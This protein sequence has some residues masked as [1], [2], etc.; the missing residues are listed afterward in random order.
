[1]PPRKKE[2]VDHFHNFAE[3]FK[4]NHILE[5]DIV[6]REDQIVDVMTF[7]DSPDLLNLP[8]NNF[9]LWLGQRVV[10]KTF[11]MG[12]RGNENVELTDEEWGW[13]YDRQLY[14]VIDKIKRKTDGIGPGQK[15]NFNFSE[16]H[17]VLGR[18]SSKT[19]MASV[20]V[21][22]EAYKLI[23]LGDPYQYYGL[24]YDD[25]I[26][27]L[28]AANSAKQSGRLFTQ[29][30]NRIRNSPFF[31]GR[32][33]GSASTTEIRLFTDVDL[34]K[35]EE[36]GANIAV[37][38]SIVLICGHS[39]PDTLR[40]FAAI[41]ILFDELAF[42]DEGTV[43]SGTEFYG[44]LTPSIAQFS[45]FG[46]GILVE[47]STPGPMSGIFYTIFQQANSED[48]KF[49]SI[50]SFRLSTWDFNP[51][52]PFGCE[53]LVKE[54]AKNPE[55]FSVEFGV[56]WQTKG[57]V[58]TYFP[59]DLV[60][61]SFKPFVHKHE[62]RD[63]RYEYFMHLDP[64]SK[65]DNY[66]ALV[67]LKQRYV[68]SR[69]EKRFRVVLAYHRVWKPSAGKALNLLDIDDEILLISQR[70]RPSIIT[71]DQW[72]SVHSINYLQKKG[73]RARQLPFGRT[74]KTTY[75]QNLLDLMDRDELHLYY[76]ELLMAEMLNL[77]Y[78]TTERGISIG[79]D[80]KSDV[81]TDDIIDCLAGA[82]WMAVGR[83]MRS[84]LPSS[85]IVDMGGR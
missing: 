28:N 44:A 33:D 45:K 62:R 77:K 81:S 16:L 19:I 22:Y 71:Y 43:I 56:Q 40:G 80:K 78:R 14:T 48:P 13:L 70:F 72:N 50:V 30:K 8:A 32:V 49:Q 76:D 84:Q 79:A 7:C 83:P 67:C 26:A 59:K 38:G 41:A 31:K 10:L 69:G 66:V 47:L 46:D 27:V 74:Q 58:S 15:H 35:K 4:R 12:T 57:L 63:Q 39:N 24:P 34:R 29:I 54:E 1:M 20:I 11:Y 68:T 65:R 6:N 37:E 18:R 55:L 36:G 2:K 75:Y 52:L 53:F 82:S 85:V 21:C 64:A 3:S 51:T 73:M 25:E 42:Y 5:E 61:Q 60:E 17:L 23:M 9:H